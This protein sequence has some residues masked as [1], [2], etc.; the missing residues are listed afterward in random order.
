MFSV[1]RLH[2]IIF[3][4]FSAGEFLLNIMFFST[5]LALIAC[6]DFSLNIE[7]RE[8][9]LSFHLSQS[10]FNPLFLS[11]LTMYWFSSSW[12][13]AHWRLTNLNPND[14]SDSKHWH[15][16]H[17]LAIRPVVWSVVWLL[18]HPDFSQGFSPWCMGKMD[19]R[20]VENVKGQKQLCRKSSPML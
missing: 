1:L 6:F 5:G 4:R 9:V 19:M 8:R 17:Y 15:A 16:S 12:G 13:N 18:T 7:W 20:N 10:Q 11:P 2:T 14:F 3:K